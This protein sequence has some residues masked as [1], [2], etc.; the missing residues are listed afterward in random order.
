M[1]QRAKRMVC[2][3]FKQASSAVFLPFGHGVVRD[4]NPVPI[5]RLFSVHGGEVS[6]VG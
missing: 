1:L 5:A 6:G 3:F 2:P 4:F